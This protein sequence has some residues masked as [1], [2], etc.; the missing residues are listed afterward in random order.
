M[1]KLPFRKSLLATALVLSI[2]LTSCKNETTPADSKEVAEEQNEVAI[3][4]AKEELNEAED[5]SQV[6]IDVAE[7]DL[8]QKELAVLAQKRAVSPD[9]KALAKKIEAGHA[10][11]LKELAD[12]TKDNGIAIPTTLTENG[13][14]E[15]DALNKKQG[16]DFDVEYIDKAITSHKDAIDKFRNEASKVKDAEV[17]AW[18]DKKVVE[19]Q[20]HFDMIN[21]LISKSRK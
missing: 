17:K 4:D 1:K 20:S 15:V 18:L 6:Y 3:E 19:I 7:F 12:A 2:S 10:T 11:S 16:Q 9:V 21:E 8:T 5:N 14:K 13:K